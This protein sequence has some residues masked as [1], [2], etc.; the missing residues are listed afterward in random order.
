MKREDD[1]AAR[2]AHLK[3]MDDEALKAY[4]WELAEKVMDPLLEMGYQ[5]TSPSIER[6]VLLRMGFSSVEVKPIV[7]G[8]LAHDLLGHGAGNLVYRLAKAKGM[9]I[10]QAG[11]ALARGECWEDTKALFKEAQ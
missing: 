3:Q 1:Y 6:S 4:F 9:P 8:A 5:N 2:S 7:E 10:R 11:L